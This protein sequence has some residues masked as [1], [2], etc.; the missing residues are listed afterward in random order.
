MSIEIGLMISILA[1]AVV[2][3]SL[4]RLPPDVTA[5]GLLLAVTV[6]GLV[7]PSQAFSG[8]GSEVV[9]MILG[10][11]ILTAALIQT[12]VVDYLGREIL[13]R[14]KSTT[15]SARMLIIKPISMLMTLSRGCFF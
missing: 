6:T 10:L 5:L 3:F 4:E 7:S 12:G 8:F 11:L 14:E 9:L 13:S 15:A 2:L 1:L